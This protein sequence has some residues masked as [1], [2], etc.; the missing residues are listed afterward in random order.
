MKKT[1]CMKDFHHINN[2]GLRWQITSSK[3]R[4]NLIKSATGGKISWEILNM[5]ILCKCFMKDLLGKKKVEESYN[6]SGKKN[7][8]LRF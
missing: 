4:Y 6:K 7:N 3:W 8:I 5:N 1:G 2:V